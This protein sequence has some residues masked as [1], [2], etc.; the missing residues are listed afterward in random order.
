MSVY[1]YYIHWGLLWQPPLLIY[2]WTSSFPLSLAVWI[3]LS[4]QSRSMID[5]CLS[6]LKWQVWEKHFL[7]NSELMFSYCDRKGKKNKTNGDALLYYLCRPAF[8]HSISD[9]FSTS[10]HPESVASVRK[11]RRFK[12]NFHRNQTSAASRLAGEIRY[13]FG[14]S[15]GSALQNGAK[16]DTVWYTAEEKAWFMA[17][18]NMS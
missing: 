6:I 14:I 10:L 11:R 15:H 9:H 17:L 1:L 8:P 13:R 16:S 2:T 4:L 7:V 18:K 3:H 5:G 12:L